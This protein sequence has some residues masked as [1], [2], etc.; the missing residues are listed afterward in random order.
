MVPV[1]GIEPPLED[2]KST[3]IPLYYTGLTIYLLG[4]NRR[5]G[6]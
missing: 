3:V 6:L 5:C 4:V 1:D 2:Y